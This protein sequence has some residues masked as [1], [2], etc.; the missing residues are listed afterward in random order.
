MFLSGQ[1]SNVVMAKK[2]K[3]PFRTKQSI[4]TRLAQEVRLI[5][6][7]MVTTVIAENARPARRLTRP[8]VPDVRRYWLMR[9]IVQVL[10]ANSIARTATASQIPTGLEEY[11]FIE[12]EK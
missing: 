5:S 11:E 9:I 10:K 12:R 1:F 6:P 4:A 3:A 8:S 2:A 7:K